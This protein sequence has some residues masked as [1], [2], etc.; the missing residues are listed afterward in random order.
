MDD[1][2]LAFA[3]ADERPRGK[4]PGIIGYVRTGVHSQDDLWN[5]FEIISEITDI[6]TIAIESS[7]DEVSRLR[8]QYGHCVMH[9]QACIR[10]RVGQR[11]DLEGRLALFYRDSV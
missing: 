7:I 5:L 8:R 6:E 3:E 11:R 10:R 2:A 1:R 4:F 9:K